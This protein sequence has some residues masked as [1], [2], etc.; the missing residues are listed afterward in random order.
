MAHL[1]ALSPGHT[2]QDA[3]LGSG[4]QAGP[5]QPGDE[6]GGGGAVVSAH[7]G[8]QGGHS[9]VVQ[10]Q[11]AAVRGVGIQR[12]QSGLP[13]LDQKGDR[14]QRG[15]HTGPRARSPPRA[16]PAFPGRPIGPL[17]AR[18]TAWHPATLVESSPGA[19]GPAGT[20]LLGTL[21]ARRPGLGLFPPARGQG[22]GATR[23]GRWRL[24][25]G[26]GGRAGRAAGA[27]LRAGVAAWQA[28]PA[29][30]NGR[31]LSGLPGSRPRPGRGL[32]RCPACASAGRM[33]A[34]A[35]SPPR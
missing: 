14:T 28:A 22:P 33:A 20:P 15:L 1:R 3:A 7:P 16:T 6:V 21:G 35:R 23:K 25:P 32:R 31:A 29:R 10:V 27:G 19:G 4:G 2:H 12:G 17:G 26:C 8:G 5:H 11:G 30:D 13:E 34:A 18:V 24:P 9:G